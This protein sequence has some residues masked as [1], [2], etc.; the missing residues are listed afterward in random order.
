MVIE[1][2]G[3]TTGIVIDR[4]EDDHRFLSNFYPCDIIVDSLLWGEQRHKSVEHAYQ[5]EKA[6]CADD[7]ASIRCAKTPGDAKRLGRATTLQ[8][9]WTD[10]YRIMFMYHCLMQKFSERNPELLDLLLATGDAALVEGNDWGDTFFGVCNGVGK[11]HLGR[12]LMIVRDQ[13]RNEY[14]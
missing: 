14:E 2:V 11:N 9:A 1:F 10:Q 6:A 4:F 8:A 5:A 13:R 7:Y 12:L 3:A